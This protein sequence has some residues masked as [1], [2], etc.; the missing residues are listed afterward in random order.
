MH[1]GEGVQWYAIRDEDTQATAQHLTSCESRHLQAR[2]H[3]GSHHS[4]HE[5]LEAHVPT[6]PRFMSKAKT[7]TRVG[8]AISISHVCCHC[9]LVCDMIVRRLHHT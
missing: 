7:T 4:L 3:F 9:F 2:N 5:A 1:Q 8:F 6:Q